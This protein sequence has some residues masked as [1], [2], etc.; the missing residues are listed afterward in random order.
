[1][2]ILLVLLASYV[3][4]VLVNIMIELAYVWV[5]ESIGGAQSME[6]IKQ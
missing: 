3:L 5:A 1:M 4:W 6:S 2:G